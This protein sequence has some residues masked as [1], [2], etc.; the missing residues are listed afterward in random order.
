MHG[1]WACETTRPLARRLTLKA[2]TNLQCRAIRRAG[3]YSR[4]RRQSCSLAEELAATLQAG[5]D[6]ARVALE[7]HVGKITLTVKSE[8]PKP[9]YWASGLLDFGPIDGGLRSQG[10]AGTRNWLPLMTSVEF[11][12]RVA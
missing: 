2:R 9:T 1:E 6:R 3:A 5:K 10:V 11:Q 8:G 4:T 7:R 12:L